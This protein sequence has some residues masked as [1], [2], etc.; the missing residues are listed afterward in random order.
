MPRIPS[1][2]KSFP[3]EL[4]PYQTDLCSKTKKASLSRAKAATG[5]SGYSIPDRIS[6]CGRFPMKTHIVHADNVCPTGNTESIGNGGPQLPL[7]FEAAKDCTDK[8]LP[9]DSE[10]NRA[11]DAGKSSHIL[12]YAEVMSNCFPKTD[13]GI[14]YY[15]RAFDSA[16]YSESNTIFK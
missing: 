7:S 3:I 9:G 1:V 16:I 6:H 5:L 13:A 10:K 2:P 8:S 11:A 14:D 4:P 15:L 12:D